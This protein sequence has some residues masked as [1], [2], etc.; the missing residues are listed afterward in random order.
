MQRVIIYCI[1][2][3]KHR[4]RYA[5]KKAS[6]SHYGFIQHDNRTDLSKYFLFFFFCVPGCNVLITTF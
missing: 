3:V 2:P 4:V 6:S 5:L 1:K